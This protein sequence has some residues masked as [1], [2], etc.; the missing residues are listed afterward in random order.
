MNYLQFSVSP[1]AWTTNRPL[2]RLS[3]PVRD[4]W[5]SDL[6]CGPPAVG[7]IVLERRR[8]VGVA[9]GHPL[10]LLLAEVLNSAGLNTRLFRRSADMK[11]SKMLTN[12]PANASAPS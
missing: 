7:D 3:D 6:I 12:L 4:R 11:W 9:D 2:N 5:N 8:G 1:T 10:Y